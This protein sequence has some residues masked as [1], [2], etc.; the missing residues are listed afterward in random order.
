MDAKP[1]NLKTAID[2]LRAELDI[3]MSDSDSL[4]QKALFVPGFT[5]ALAAFVIAPASQQGTTLQLIMIAAAVLLGAATVVA[6]FATLRP[7][8]TNLGP[9]ASQLANGLGLE[10]ADFDLHVVGSLV[11]AVNSQT[12][13][14]IAKSKRLWIAMRLAIATLACIVAARLVGGS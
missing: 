2:T 4:D 10:P 9:N 1:D 5:V 6:G 3:A 8:A 7:T 14:N 13:S 12:D 11:Q